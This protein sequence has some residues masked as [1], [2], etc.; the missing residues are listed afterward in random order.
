[1]AVA[2][3]TPPS[4][5]TAASIPRQRCVPA[6]RKTHQERT[7]NASEP[8][9]LDIDRTPQDVFETQSARWDNQTISAENIPIC[10]FSRRFTIPASPSVSVPGFTQDSGEIQRHWIHI[11]HT[12]YRGGFPASVPLK[13][14]ACPRF[15]LHRRPHGWWP[16]N[17]RLLWRT[18]FR[19]R[20]GT[21][22]WLRAARSQRG[23]M[24]HRP[25]RPP[26]WRSST[27]CANSLTRPSNPNP[28]ATT[29][30]SI[31]ELPPGKPCRMC[32]FM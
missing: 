6:R 19:S 31:P 2:T 32:I 5:Q 17:W 28:M 3:L 30:A 18:V 9:R 24:P 16:T 4:G 29:L 21:R 20:Q 27:K 13:S 25:N 14:T 12:H 22:W 7:R 23:L 1:M 10:T 8:H 15:F 11:P 26:C